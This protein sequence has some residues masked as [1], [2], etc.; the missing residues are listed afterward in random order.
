MRDSDEE[1]FA[2]GL[3]SPLNVNAV[4]IDEASMLDLPL[5]AA[6]LDALPRDRETHLVLIG[7]PS[8]FRVR[9]LVRTRLPRLAMCLT[10]GNICVR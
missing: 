2:Y 7:A 1:D 8:L 10:F 5:A 6:L 3:G 4:L 9:V